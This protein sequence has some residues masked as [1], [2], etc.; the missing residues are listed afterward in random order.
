MDDGGS[1]APGR[2]AWSSMLWSRPPSAAPLDCLV[3]VRPLQVESAESPHCIAL[4]VATVRYIV[5]EKPAVTCDDAQTPWSDEDRHL[6][7]KQKA[8]GSSPTVS[9]T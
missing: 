8:V 3:E 2:R 5:E 7:C 1:T 9:T 6:L 4:Q